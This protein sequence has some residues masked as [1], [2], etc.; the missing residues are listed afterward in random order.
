MARFRFAPPVPSRPAF[1]WVD[2]LIL[3]GLVAGLAL[4]VH[5]LAGRA[6]AVVAGPRITLSYAALPWYALLSTSRMAAASSPAAS[7]ASR[8]SSGSSRR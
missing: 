5:R 8:P 2:G 1:S 6:P 3:A 4:A 7:C